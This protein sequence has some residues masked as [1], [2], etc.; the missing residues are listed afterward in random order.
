[1]CPNQSKHCVAAAIFSLPQ[2]NSFPSLLGQVL[3][4]VFPAQTLSLIC[5]ASMREHSRCMSTKISKWHML[6]M[7]Y[8]FRTLC[9]CSL[10]V[11]SSLDAFVEPKRARCALPQSSWPT[12]GAAL[13]NTQ[14]QNLA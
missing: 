3:A 13:S 1:M 9:K 2:Q 14:G 8:D 12:A 6:H 11:G 7:H 10:A 5:I 4:F